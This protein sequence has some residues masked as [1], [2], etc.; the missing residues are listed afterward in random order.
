LILE[1]GYDSLDN[2]RT[3]LTPPWTELELVNDLAGWAR[4]LVAG[5]S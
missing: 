2:V 5:L 3:F 1:L 4:V